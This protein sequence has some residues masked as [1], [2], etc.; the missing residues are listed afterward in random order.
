M[1]ACAQV[2]AGA[3][4]DSSAALAS[5]GGATLV[6]APRKK[7]SNASKSR[8]AS[9]R[10]LS[11]SERRKLEK[12]EKERRLRAQRAAAFETMAA[13][14]LPRAHAALLAPSATMGKRATR[15]EEARRGLAMERAG[16]VEEDA[17]HLKRRKI[18]DAGADANADA[19]DPE[20]AAAAAAAAAEAAA[21]AAAA[22][23]PAAVAPMPLTADVDPDADDWDA[24]ADGGGE[25]DV[26]AFLAARAAEDA[27][28]DT[29]GR[30]GAELLDRDIIPAKA[31]HRP[32][33]VRVRVR[34][35]MR[36]FAAASIQGA[37][38]K[39]AP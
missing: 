14:A 22:A 16:V 6:S 13:A 37:F 12:L 4:L 31:Y 36:V 10:P 29:V 35:R 34:V 8:P 24:D 39:T 23:A 17:P 38:T 3:L 21:F 32:V 2:D 7:G 33:K 19:D 26:P 18:D 9:A 27:A 28:G 11:K 30:A 5:G 25:F 20:L 15:R 1:C